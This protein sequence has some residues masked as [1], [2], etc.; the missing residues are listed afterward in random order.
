VISKCRIN[1]KKLAGKMIMKIALIGLTL[2]IVLLYLLSYRKYT[3]D[4]VPLDPRRYTLKHFIVIGLYILDLFKHQYNTSYDRML[5]SKIIEISGA[6]QSKYYLKIHLANKIVLLLLC[7]E[8]VLIIGA[9]ITPDRGF[10]FFSCL[11][12]LAIIY[13]TDNELNQSIHKRRIS[14]QIDFPDFLN[15]LVLLINAGMTVPRAW[16]RAVSNSSNTGPLYNE[17]KTVLTEIRSGKPETRAYTDFAKRCKTPEITRFVSIMLQNLKKGNTELVYI[18][19]VHSND[20]WQMRK[21]AAKSHCI[22]I[23]DS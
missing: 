15:K 9:I 3:D 22:F 6:K 18:L 17:L 10:W 5:Y 1:R 8:L 13:L 16:E 7:M 14:L 2:S 19:R 23:I 4:V 20:C 12:L 11:F 21:N